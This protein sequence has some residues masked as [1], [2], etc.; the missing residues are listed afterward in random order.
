MDEILGVEKAGGKWYI[1]VD[2]E[3]DN[4][5]S[6]NIYGKNPPNSKMMHWGEVT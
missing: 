4:H 5:S 6:Y 2:Y 3:Y 1:N